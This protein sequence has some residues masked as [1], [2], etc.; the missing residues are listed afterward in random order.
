ML[1]KPS[2]VMVAK[3]DAALKDIFKAGNAES[4]DIF[5]MVLPLRS[6]V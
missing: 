2:D 5:V 6:L 1:A 4:L 3:D